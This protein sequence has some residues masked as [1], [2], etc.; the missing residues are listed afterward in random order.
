MSIFNRDPKEVLS[1]VAAI[2]GAVVALFSFVSSFWA[3]SES[4]KADLL[5]RSLVATKQIVELSD[6][7]NAVDDQVKRVEQRIQSLS[8]IPK[9]DALNIEIQNLKASTIELTT[10]QG[11]N[12][13]AILES[14]S[15]ALEIP[16]LRRD[17][18]SVRQLQQ[19]GL[20]AMKESVDRIYDLSKWLMG[21]I[22]VSIVSL[23]LSNLLKPRDAKPS[24]GK[25]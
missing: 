15:K 6:K 5:A 25:D 18:D 8:A 10:K 3:Q 12:K 4:N 11:K 24:N 2:A 21:G 14:P 13:S 16:L 19:S 22:A 1:I 20:V 9:E 17:L 23:A 7:L